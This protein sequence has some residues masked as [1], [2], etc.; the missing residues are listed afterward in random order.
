MS[1][2]TLKQICKLRPTVFSRDRAETVTEINDLANIDAKRFFDET[3][4]TDGIATLVRRVFQRLTG[5]QSDQGV[6]RLKQAMGGGDPQ[7]TGGGVFGARCRPAQIDADKARA[8]RRR[9]GDEGLGVLRTR[10]RQARL[11]VGADLPR[12]GTRPAL[13]ADHGGTRALE[14]G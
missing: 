4:V 14:L 7:P 6:Y 9:P 13:E 12:P 11:P 2:L 3:H 1:N 10:N 5:G 8:E